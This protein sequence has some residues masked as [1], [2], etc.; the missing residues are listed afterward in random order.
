MVNWTSPCLCS[1]FSASSVA[2]NIFSAPTCKATIINLE[3]CALNA[4]FQHFILRFNKISLL[5]GYPQRRVWGERR[6]KD[7]VTSQIIS[8]FAFTHCKTFTQGC[9]SAV[10]KYLHWPP[11]SVNNIYIHRNRI[12]VIVKILNR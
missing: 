11:V 9:V 10:D 12:S 3:P 4:E 8:I 2:V 7:R 5:Y 6:P 1:F